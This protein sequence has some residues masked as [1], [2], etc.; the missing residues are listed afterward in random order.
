MAV[1]HAR[2][3]HQKSASKKA[4]FINGA[5]DDA[6][7]LI[8]ASREDGIDRSQICRCSCRSKAPFFASRNRRNLANFGSW[9]EPSKMGIWAKIFGVESSK[10]EPWAILSCARCRRVYRLGK[11]SVAASLEHAVSLGGVGGIIFSDG[12]PRQRE[13]LISSIETVSG[14]TV[15]S[16]RDRAQPSWEIIRASLS[17]GDRRSWRCQAC[18]AL[19]TYPAQLR[20]PISGQARH[21]AVAGL[22][23]IRYR[24]HP[25]LPM[26]CVNPVE[27]KS[28]ILIKTRLFPPRAWAVPRAQAAAAA[29]QM[30]EKQKSYI[31]D[32]DKSKTIEIIPFARLFDT[33]Q[34]NV[35]GGGVVTGYYP[36]YCAVGDRDKDMVQLLLASGADVNATPSPLSLA[37][38]KGDTEIFELL[39]AHGANM[40]K[41]S[42]LRTA[43][44]SGQKH[45][46]EL[47]LDNGA[48]VNGK[49]KVGQ[50]PLREA[51]S[52]GHTDIVELLL[53]KG[54]DV[55]C[56]DNVGQTPLRQAVSNGHTDTVELLLSKGAD[57]NCKDGNGETPLRIAVKWDKKPV[58][59]L[60]RRYGGHE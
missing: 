9:K 40:D 21:K 49:D 1:N 59:E 11:D 32:W 55:N 37:I 18:D 27:A 16:I 46:V 13:D 24:P 45:L 41:E 30:K 3:L 7:I 2:I 35:S 57:V 19:N 20:M 34:V 29:A 58:A 56:K 42:S 4:N 15:Q 28:S 60:L 36:L 23:V 6:K 52:N 53:S 12:R 54:A 48:D 26:L 22:F 33:D 51:A 39:L 17:R 31:D 8:S 44:S 38:S 47:L 10:A 5:A 50:A 14:E 25:L 43:A